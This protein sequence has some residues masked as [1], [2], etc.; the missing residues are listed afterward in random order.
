[1]KTK[2]YLYACASL[3]AMLF[4]GS[5]ADE[6]HVDPTAGRT[7]ITSLTAY[8]TSGEY[9]D[10]AAKEWIVDGNEE[11]T[12]YV[13]PVPYYFPEESDNSTAE[14]LKLSLIHI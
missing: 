2:K 1:M 7:G 14:A 3:V 5:C 9:R 12:D 11:I 6:E 4:M 13:I 8:F 10:K